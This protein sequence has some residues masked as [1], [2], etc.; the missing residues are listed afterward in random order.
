ME[1]SRTALRRLKAIDDLQA[2]I[3]FG[4]EHAQALLEDYAS[5]IK[6][7]ETSSDLCDS[8]GRKFDVVTSEFQGNFRASVFFKKRNGKTTTLKRCSELV[9]DLPI[10]GKRAEASKIH[11]A[12]VKYLEAA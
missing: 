10:D 12:V 9:L 7:N 2:C 1:F 3:G 5:E 8:I 6:D 11:Y 4:F